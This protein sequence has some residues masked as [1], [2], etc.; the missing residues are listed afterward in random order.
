MWDSKAKKRLQVQHLIFE[1]KIAPTIRKRETL[2]FL[3]EGRDIILI[4]YFILFLTTYYSQLILYQNTIV[5][6]NLALAS[7]IT[8][9]FF[10]SLVVK[11]IFFFFC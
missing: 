4:K 5:A 3:I 2:S 11:Y 6:K 10:C 8:H 7:L 1:A 9:Y